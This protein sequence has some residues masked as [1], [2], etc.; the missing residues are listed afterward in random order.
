[1]Y[2][3]SELIRPL[4]YILTS[5]VHLHYPQCSNPKK[6]ITVFKY[7]FVHR[8]RKGSTLPVILSVKLCHLCRHF[9]VCDYIHIRQSLNPKYIISTM[10][11]SVN[12]VSTKPHCNRWAHLV[13]CC[14][15]FQERVTERGKNSLKVN[16]D[17]QNFKTLPRP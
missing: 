3:I 10:D 17:K 7:I 5:N 13:A 14:C 6:S 16:Q 2:N 9:S 12:H 15:N 4:F 1:M 8:L 11:N